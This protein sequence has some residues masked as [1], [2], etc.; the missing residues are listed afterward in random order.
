MPNISVAEILKMHGNW[1]K[2]ETLVSLVEQ[3]MGI[4]D[5]MAYIKIKEALQKK[6]QILRLQLQ[7]GTVLY[8]L[9]E[10]GEPKQLGSDVAKLKKLGF[11]GWLNARAER[12]RTLQEKAIKQQWADSWSYMELLGKT[13]PQAHICKEMVE[14]EKKRYREA[15]LIDPEKKKVDDS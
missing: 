7:D 14:I 15:G 9:P 8:G 5:R 4:S 12:K 3:K 6:K 2:S 11:F 10:F 1:T 13:N